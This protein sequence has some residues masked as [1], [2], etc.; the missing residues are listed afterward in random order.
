MI[1]MIYL[2]FKTSYKLFNDAAIE[3]KPM[4]K[5]FVQTLTAINQFLDISREK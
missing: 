4:Y 3:L 5:L 2:D 1:I